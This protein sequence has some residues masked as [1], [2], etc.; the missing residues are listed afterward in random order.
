M[1]VEHLVSPCEIGF[2][3]FLSA[4]TGL[5]HTRHWSRQVTKKRFSWLKVQIKE[6]EIV[7]NHGTVFWRPSAHHKTFLVHFKQLFSLSMLYLWKQILGLIKHLFKH[8]WL[9]I[10]ELPCLS[11]NHVYGTNAWL[12]KAC[13]PH[14]KDLYDLKERRGKAAIAISLCSSFAKYMICVRFDCTWNEP[15]DSQS[16]EITLYDTAMVDTS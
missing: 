14:V 9:R 11:G 4:D 7:I 10:L 5:L 8:Q 1:S 15:E 2:W 16:S 6:E 3:V 12:I 13:L